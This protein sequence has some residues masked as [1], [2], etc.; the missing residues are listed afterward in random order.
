MLSTILIQNKSV[1][2]SKSWE[3]VSISVSVNKTDKLDNK[4]ADIKTNASVSKIAESI[5]NSS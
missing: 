5:T 4:N 2:Y 1:S 3:K